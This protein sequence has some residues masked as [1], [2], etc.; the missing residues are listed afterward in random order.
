ML[1]NWAVKRRSA[2]WLAQAWRCGCQIVCWIG[3][4]EQCESPQ[5]CS[6]A[7]QGMTD[8]W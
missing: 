2:R 8:C 6:L 4:V 7:C 3:Y 5:R 1:P